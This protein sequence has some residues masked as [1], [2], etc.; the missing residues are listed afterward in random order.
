M[1]SGAWLSIKDYIL[2]RWFSVCLIS[3]TAADMVWSQIRLAT[4]I[5]VQCHQVQNLYKDL[6]WLRLFICLKKTIKIW[7]ICF[8]CVWFDLSD[9]SRFSPKHFIDLRS[10]RKNILS[11]TDFRLIN[12]ENSCR[13]KNI[14]DQNA[15]QVDILTWTLLWQSL[16]LDLPS[17]GTNEKTFQW[18]KIV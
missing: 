15:I 13:D 12:Q 4:I 3:I 10:V 6:L 9:I 1:L 5:T 16:T 18:V 14:P 2:S 17:N 7:N 11:L 8:N